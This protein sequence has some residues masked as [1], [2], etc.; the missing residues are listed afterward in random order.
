MSRPHIQEWM[1]VWAYGAWW[2]TVFLVAVAI[3]AYAVAKIGA[4]RAPGLLMVIA[5]GVEATLHCKLMPLFA[6]AWISHV[7]AY[8]QRAPA[9]QW[10]TRFS[11]RRFGFVLCVWLLVTTIDL[12]D[13]VRWQFWRLRVPQ[14]NTTFAYPVGAVDYLRQQRFVG[15]LMV[16]FQH[17]AYVSWKLYPAVKVSVD[18]RYEVAYSDEWVDRMFRFYAAEPGWR[19]TLTAY[20][21]DL[22]LVPRITPV[23]RMIQQGDWQIVYEDREFEI[24]ARPGLTLSFTDHTSESFAGVFP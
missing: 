19:E 14:T 18:S 23:A 8:L 11:R 3:T 2:T 24:F 9:G 12:A 13:A 22:V 16:P 20:A 6:I 15:H 10:I 4:L 5:T 21:T 7:P 17:G 1:P